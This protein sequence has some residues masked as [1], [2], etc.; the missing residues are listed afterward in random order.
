MPQTL[1]VQT[2]RMLFPQLQYNS[3][4]FFCLSAFRPLPGHRVGWIC[5]LPIVQTTRGRIQM[6]TPTLRQCWQRYRRYHRSRNFVSSILGPFNAGCTMIMFWQLV[7]LKQH[8][9]CCNCGYPQQGPFQPCRLCSGNIGIP[10][11]WR[12]WGWPGG[13]CWRRRFDQHQILHL[14]GLQFAGGEAYPDV[15]IWVQLHAGARLPL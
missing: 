13:S 10:F 6:F 7:V 8:Q 3:N 12:S 9:D 15:A 11:R 5:F 4:M 1:S 14:H 2:T